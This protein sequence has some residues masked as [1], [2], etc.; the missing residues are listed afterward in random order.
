MIGAKVLRL[1]D[2]FC[3]TKGLASSLEVQRCVLGSISLLARG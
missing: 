3:G 2:D 1:S